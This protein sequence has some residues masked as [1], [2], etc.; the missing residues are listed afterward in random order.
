MGERT[1]S[2][3]LLSAY[4]VEW[5][6][7]RIYWTK[8]HLNG[9]RNVN[10]AQRIVNLWGEY[11]QRP[12]Y[13]MQGTSSVIPVPPF[14][15]DGWSLLTYSPE[16]YWKQYGGVGASRTEEDLEREGHKFGLFDDSIIWDAPPPVQREIHLR[17]KRVH[18]A[19]I[20]VARAVQGGT[21]KHLIEQLLNDLKVFMYQLIEG[22]QEHSS[23]FPVEDFIE[24][25]KFWYSVLKN[26]QQRQWSY[27]DINMTDVRYRGEPTPIPY[28]I[29]CVPPEKSPTVL[30]AIKSEFDRRLYSAKR[31]LGHDPRESGHRPELLLAYD[32]F[33]EVMSQPSRNIEP[34]RRVFSIE[35]KT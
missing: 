33:D 19:G 34:G 15:D 1:L 32:A 18:Q 21:E 13:W 26:Q 14:T 10:T 22:T 17:A 2:H 12:F 25:T 35:E 23:P 16:S 11:V 20:G 27:R 31:Q 5:Q 8:N 3:N 9:W 28:Y 30:G 6:I 7:V 24:R 4:D 29:W